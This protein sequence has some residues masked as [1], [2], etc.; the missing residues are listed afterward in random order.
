MFRFSYNF[1]EFAYLLK[2]VS[3]PSEGS[4]QARGSSFIVWHHL[5]SV[6]RSYPKI[7]N[8]IYAFTTEIDGTTRI[9]HRKSAVRPDYP[10]L[11]SHPGQNREL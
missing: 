2:T 10:L 7:I 9:P 3:T 11:L 4:T 6:E 5:Q 1:F 8:I